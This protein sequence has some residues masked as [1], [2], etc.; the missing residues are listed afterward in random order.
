MFLSLLHR[1]DQDGQLHEQQTHLFCPEITTGNCL[2]EKG[3]LRLAQ[4]FKTLDE[5]ECCTPYRII[6]NSTQ[7]ASIHDKNIH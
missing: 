4:I 5:C 6:I 7:V 2:H 3:P 1:K